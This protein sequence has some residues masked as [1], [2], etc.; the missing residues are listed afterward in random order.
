MRRFEKFKQNSAYV[1]ASAIDANIGDILYMREGGKVKAVKYIAFE[2]RNRPEQKSE[3]LESVCCYLVAGESF[4]RKIHPY[5]VH[6]YRSIS[7][8][9]QGIN[10]VKHFS[11]DPVLVAKEV[12]I[13]AKDDKIPFTLLYEWD[14]F[15]PRKK[16]VCLTSFVIRYDGEYWDSNPVDGRMFYNTFEECEEANYLEVVTFPETLK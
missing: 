1:S 7:D 12:G 13:E 5:Y 11:I 9:R 4:E 2:M 10:E 15:Y 3:H 6:F 16:H 14:G 8:C